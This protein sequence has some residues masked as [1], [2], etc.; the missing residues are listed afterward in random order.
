[1]PQLDS[2]TFPYSDGNLATVSG[3]K[4]AKLSAFAD[5]KVVSGGVRGIASTDCQG[6]IAVWTGSLIDQYAQCTWTNF[7]HPQYCGP[8]ICSNGVDSF[9]VFDARANDHHIF[10]VTPGPTYTDLASSPALGL[11]SGDTLYIERVAGRITC[12]VNGVTAVSVIDS[13]LTGKPGL[14]TFEDGVA[15]DNWVAGDFAAPATGGAPA[16]PTALGGKA[17]LIGGSW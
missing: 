3:G 15:L 14:R 8:M 12:K 7:G 5:L 11:A 16:D 2:D 10:K 17:F 9:Y 13:T 6:Q 4:W 1:M